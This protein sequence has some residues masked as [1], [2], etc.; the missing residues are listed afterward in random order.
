MDIS[1]S[2]SKKIERVYHPD[3]RLV[4]EDQLIRWKLGQ[5]EFLPLSLK[6]GVLHSSS[7]DPQVED[8]ANS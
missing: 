1:I 4:K 8:R 7:G 5:V 3:S 6:D 2:I